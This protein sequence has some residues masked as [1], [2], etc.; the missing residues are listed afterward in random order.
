MEVTKG[1]MVIAHGKKNGTLYVTSNKENIMAI[2][3]SDEK[4]KLWHDRLGHISEKG[5][6]FLSKGKLSSLKSVDLGLC[7]LH[8]RQTEKG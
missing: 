6:V 2:A 3:D 5:M 7:G 8:L 1:A 4:S